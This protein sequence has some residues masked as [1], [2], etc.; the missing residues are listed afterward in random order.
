MRRRRM[1]RKRGGGVKLKVLCIHFG[2]PLRC[3]FAPSPRIDL[4]SAWGGSRKRRRGEEYWVINGKS[5]SMHPL[6]P[7]FAN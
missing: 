7:S 4:E 2:E 1:K 6:P 3:F 5:R